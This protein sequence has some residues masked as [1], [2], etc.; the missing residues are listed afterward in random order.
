MAVVWGI[1][2]DQPSLDL[3]AGGFVSI[4]WS[5]VGDLREVDTDREALK[6]RLAA[7]YPMARPGAIPVWAGVLARFVDEMAV[8]DLVVSPHR[9]TRTLNF[10]VVDGDFYVEP[11]APVHPNRRPVR[12]LETDVP[13]DL[14]SRPALYELGSSVTLFRVRRHAPELLRVVGMA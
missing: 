13:R 3:V 10:G 7:T 1:H 12:W 6:A 2:N 8:G 9:W 14:F 5:A 11:A 4:G